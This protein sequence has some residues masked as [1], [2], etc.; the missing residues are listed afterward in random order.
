MNTTFT[1]PNNPNQSFTQTGRNSDGTQTWVRNDGVVF[2]NVTEDMFAQYFGKDAAKQ[3]FYDPESDK[4]PAAGKQRTGDAQLA[5]SDPE[6]YQYDPGMDKHSDQRND[7][8]NHYPF[9]DTPEE[10]ARNAWNQREY[11][12]RQSDGSYKGKP[13]PT[14]ADGHTFLERGYYLDE[15]ERSAYLQW[16]HDNDASNPL[17]NVYNP[18][19]QLSPEQ[20]AQ[21]QRDYE[22]YYEKGPGSGITPVP[23]GGTGRT[24]STGGTGGT[25]RTGPT[26]STGGTG[27]TGPTG[28]TGGPTGATGTTGGII[29]PGGVTGGTGGL[30]INP[31]PVT[32]P[33]PTGPGLIFGARN[34]GVQPYR[35]TPDGWSGTNLMQGFKPVTPP[36][37]TPM[38][39]VKPPAS[40]K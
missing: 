22:Q 2:N 40:V 29:I 6:H 39:L 34:T 10:E 13:P 25:G 27:R 20:Q 24:G 30:I 19:S 14:G 31:P 1:N 35:T 23:T 7:D 26:G 37:V 11:G 28:S 9:Q 33:A 21:H 16:L 4:T 8:P 36:T 12:Y 15:A 17:A 5:L 32:N 38:E 18:Y 3:Y